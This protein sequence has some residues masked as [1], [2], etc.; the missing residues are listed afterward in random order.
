MNTCR[1]SLAALG[2]E[3]VDL[4]LLHHA[5]P[6]KEDRIEQ[7]RALVQLQQEGLA[8]SIGVSNWNIHH[9]EQLREAGLPVPA[10]NQI[11]I[12]PL[13][14]QEPLLA[15]MRKHN[16]TPV[17]YSSLAPLN[18]WRSAPNQAS[19]KTNRS[20]TRMARLAQKYE[21]SEAQVLLRWAVQHGYAVIPKSIDPAK[22]RVNFDVF[23]FSL[24]DDDMRLLDSY[25][26]DTPLAWPGMNPLSCP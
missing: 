9:I 3:Y 11:E 6:S 20:D 21:V 14:T 1:R 13:C 26:E 16:I 15:Y 19:S 17:A 5:Q 7:Y 18:S 25:N 4:Y 23:G 2:T 12:H 10:C 22:Q 24:S 8:R